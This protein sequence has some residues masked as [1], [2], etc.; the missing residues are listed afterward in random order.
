M[1]T[2]GANEIRTFFFKN[3]S[4]RHLLCTRL[5]PIWHMRVFMLPYILYLLPIM[6]ITMV[7][8]HC[9]PPVAYRE[10]DRFRGCTWRSTICIFVTIRSFSGHCHIVWSPYGE[11]SVTSTDA[12]GRCKQVIQLPIVGG[13]LGCRGWPNDLSL[14]SMGSRLLQLRL[15][16]VTA[17]ETGR[18]RG[19]ER[20]AGE[21]VVVVRGH[22]PWNLE[23]KKMYN[24]L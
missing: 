18:W 16:M 8:K 7:M 1:L 17:A 11:F 3:P 10:A 20:Q 2:Y 4:E 13:R 15:S 23:L 6:L 5:L 19:R 9:C 24:R 14:T 12:W 22:D 21:W